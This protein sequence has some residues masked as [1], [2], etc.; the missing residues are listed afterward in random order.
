M[1]F[2]L[3]AKGALL[4]LPAGITQTVQKINSGNIGLP[5]F[6]K[7]YLERVEEIRSKV[8]EQCAP[9]AQPNETDKPRRIAI[10]FGDQFDPNA[11][12][13]ILGEESGPCTPL[14]REAFKAEARLTRSAL[15]KALEDAFFEWKGEPGNVTNSAMDELFKNVSEHPFFETTRQTPEENL[16][17]KAPSEVIT[18]VEDPPEPLFLPPVDRKRLENILVKLQEYQLNRGDI[19]LLL[20]KIAIVIA[21]VANQK[22]YLCVKGLGQIV[23]ELSLTPEECDYLARYSSSVGFPDE[24]IAQNV[25]LNGFNILPNQAEIFMYQPTPNLSALDGSI[26]QFATNNRIFSIA[27]TRIFTDAGVPGG[28]EN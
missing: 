17:P 16:Q 24:K 23:D 19:R 26:R 10:V 3:I 14:D 27:D 15:E 7:G 4:L 20:P 25:M 12:M 11:S 21:D 18:T 28:F 22:T 1:F 2:P 8:N 13:L 9:Q 5:D 6:V